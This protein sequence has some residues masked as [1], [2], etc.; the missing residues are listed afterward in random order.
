MNCATQRMPNPLR[1][2]K[3][4]AIVCAGGARC[5]PAV[6]ASV[7]P[8]AIVDRA[9]PANDRIQKGSTSLQGWLASVLPQVQRRFK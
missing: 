6:H 9:R 5:A 8:T 7:T 2:A 1:C 3:R 4:S